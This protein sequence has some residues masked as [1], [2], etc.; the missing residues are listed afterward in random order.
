MQVHDKYKGFSFDG[1]IRFLRSSTSGENAYTLCKLKQTLHMCHNLRS[2][3]A[4]CAAVSPLVLSANLPSAALL[5]LWERYVTWDANAT[6]PFI[7]LHSLYSIL[8]TSPSPL[9]PLHSLYS[10]FSTLTNSHHILHSVHFLYVHGALAGRMDITL[11][12]VSLSVHCSIR[13]VGVCRPTEDHSSQSPTVS[14]PSVVCCPRSP[15]PS[16]GFH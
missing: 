5:Y 12:S 3:S 14:C 11:L 6:S 10:T 8:A 16:P 9:R 1:D 4:F 13:P 2:G 7:P 15:L